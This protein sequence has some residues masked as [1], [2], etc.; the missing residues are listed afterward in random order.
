[1]VSAVVSEVSRNVDMGGGVAA[2][3]S[4]INPSSIGPGPDGIAPT[5]PRASAPARIAMRASSIE[6]MQHTLILVLIGRVSSE[7]TRDA[8][9]QDETG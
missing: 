5:R 1:M 4:A 8:R 2:A 3:I 6:A 7:A 9:R